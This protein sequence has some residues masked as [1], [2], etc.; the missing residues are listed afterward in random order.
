MKRTFA[1]I[2]LVLI[3]GIV[4]YFVGKSQ[5][6]FNTSGG[7][8]ADILGS[9]PELPV[10]APKP[11]GS[12]GA[13]DSIIKSDFIIEFSGK[14]IKAK[15]T[16]RPVFYLNPSGKLQKI[17]DLYFGMYQAAVPGITGAIAQANANTKL[18]AKTNAV[19]LY[20]FSLLQTGVEIPAKEVPA[21]LN[22]TS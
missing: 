10:N 20:F 19:D 1:I 5:G 3:I 18:A 9:N 17:S 16:D 7:A 11:P 14:F 12:Q 6:W 22:S 13:S 15:G 21:L 2:G 4:L 8:T